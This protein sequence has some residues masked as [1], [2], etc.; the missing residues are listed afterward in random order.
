[1]TEVEYV[2]T[3][4]AAASAY[5]DAFRTSAGDFT[6][7][8]IRLVRRWEHI[9]AALAPSTTIALA[10]TWL[11]KNRPS[12]AEA[13]PFIKQLNALVAE[14]L[15]DTDGLAFEDRTERLC[16]ALEAL[17]TSAGLCVAAAAKGNQAAMSELLEGASAHMFEHAAHWQKLGA[18][19]GRTDK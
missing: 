4:R 11:E 10:N 12:T 1:M 18:F 16:A 17:C 8:E 5:R 7:E 19:L 6:D 14:E 3:I 13:D 9:K 2:E 15:S